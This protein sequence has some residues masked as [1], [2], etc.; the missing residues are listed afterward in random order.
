M[1][2]P[3]SDDDDDSEFESNYEYTSSDDDDSIHEHQEASLFNQEP[4]SCT[5]C[6]E[7]RVEEGCAL[8][9]P[10]CSHSFCVDCFATY[11]EI[12]IGQ[13][14][15]DSITCPFILD[16]AGDEKSGSSGGREINK[17]CNAS[18]GMD[19]LRE[20]MT[21]E[22]YE[23]LMQQKD[24]AFVRKNV[25]YHHCPTPD[26]INIVL[27]KLVDM[28][29]N[30]GGGGGGRI[31]DCFKCGHTSC[32]TCGARPFH[33]K[34]TCEE[35]R[36]EQ[37]IMR[38]RKQQ[39]ELQRQR[40]WMPATADRSRANEETKYDFQIEPNGSNDH[41]S[42]ENVSDALENVKRCRRCGNG[43]ELQPGGCLKMKC[44]CGYRFCYQC[45]SENAQCDCTPSHHGF[46]D[47]RTGGGDFSGLRE[48]KSHT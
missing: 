43:V 34:K 38:I 48:A 44:I 39:R 5:I 3:D 21:Q 6:R 9:L 4:V 11:V 16:D 19:V 13:G 33:A 28:D 24:S 47:N 36:E 23:R 35:H 45:G 25:D 30:E 18:V 37:R 46:T 27:C 15:A 12:Q 2:S 20:I 14:N 31:C 7:E 26:C 29:N 42:A 40:H 8:I 22:K 1:S 32:L 41:D 10:A 17:R